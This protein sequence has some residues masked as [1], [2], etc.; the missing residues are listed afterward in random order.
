LP[1]ATT[2]AEVEPSWAKNLNL[3]I[4]PASPLASWAV[5]ACAP[6]QA[7]ETTAP[8]T[9]CRNNKS[10]APVEPYFDRTPQPSGDGPLDPLV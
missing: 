8:L 3:P 7:N 9:N 6:D 1:P 2:G 10:A 5:S 4:Y